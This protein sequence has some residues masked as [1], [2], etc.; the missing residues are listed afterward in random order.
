MS[1]SKKRK[2]IWDIISSI[3]PLLIGVFITGVGIFL[4]YTYNDRNLKLLEI[5]ILN[6][7]RPLLTSDNLEDCQYAYDAM[8]VVGLEELVIRLTNANKDQCGRGA[9]ETII[10]KQG[11]KQDSKQASETLSILDKE[12]KELELNQLVKNIYSTTRFTRRNATAI[13]ASDKW[14]KESSNLL[15]SELL[16]AYRSDRNNYFGLVNTLFLLNKVSNSS[17]E[18]HLS[19][20]GEVVQSAQNNLSTSDKTTYVIPIANKLRNYNI[21]L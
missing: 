14:I 6:E 21:S 17:F 18:A 15:V 7:F 2:D 19:E 4:T 16:L 13:L 5:R 10:K 3:S 8:A 12:A 11:S 20:I 9:L 1:D